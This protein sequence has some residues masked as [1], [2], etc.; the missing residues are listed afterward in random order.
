[1]HLKRPGQSGEWSEAAL[2]QF[3]DGLEELLGQG[4]ALGLV[5][6]LLAQEIAE[7]VH[8]PVEG[9]EGW[10]LGEEFAAA[11]SL[12]LGESIGFLSQDRETATVPLDLGSDGT[13]EFH[14]VMQDDAHD[15]EA[16][17]H[18]PSPWKVSADEGTV[19]AA[20]VDADH[21]NSLSAL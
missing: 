15:M 12:A 11:F 2:G 3:P 5:V 9:K 16:I 19:G 6:V 13:K 14:K 21:S 20:H 7:L 17:R 18:N 4:A 8:L 1:L 10:M